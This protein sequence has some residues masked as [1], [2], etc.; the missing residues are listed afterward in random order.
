MANRPLPTPETL[1]QLLDYDPATGLLTWKERPLSFFSGSNEKVRVRGW[2]IW[3]AKYP[4]KIAG[5]LTNGYVSVKIFDRM[6]LS[7]RIIWAMVY[8][9]WPDQIDHINGQP[10]DN[11]LS[12]L[13]SVSQQINQRNQR[14][15][16]TNTSGRTGVAWNRFRGCW[17]AYI[18]IG[19]RTKYLGGY[20]SFDAAVSARMVAEEEY[21][22][23]GRQ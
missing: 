23:T 21:G 13:R 16:K 9:I 3:N 6:H 12:N 5:V 18:R 8:G 11:R 19:K 17:V 20:Q 1:R 14:R 2:K 7:H 10:S 4:G 15:H 22:F